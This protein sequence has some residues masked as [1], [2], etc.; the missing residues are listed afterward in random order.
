MLSGKRV[1]VG[2]NGLGLGDGFLGLWARVVVRDLN[3]DFTGVLA[4]AGEILPEIVLATTG[5]DDV[6]QVDPCLSNQFCLL[7]VVEDG[8]FE[9]V[10]VGGVVDGE[11]DFLIPAMFL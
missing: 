5:D 1:T 3:P 9:L 11:A 2:V 10:I 6:A 4:L 7:V 8:D